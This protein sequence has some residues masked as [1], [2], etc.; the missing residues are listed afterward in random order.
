MQLAATLS[1]SAP[2]AVTAGGEGGVV[3]TP[4][5]EGVGEGAFERVSQLGSHAGAGR[6]GGVVQGAPGQ[7]VVQLVAPVLPASIVWSCLW[8]VQPQ[9]KQSCEVP[10]PQRC[11]E[12]GSSKCA[13]QPAPWHVLICCSS[14]HTGQSGCAAT[15]APGQRKAGAPQALRVGRDPLAV[16]DL[17]V[18][19]GR[20]LQRVASQTRLGYRG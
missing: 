17:L 7:V 18:H 11:T 6:R 16:V 13:Q 9:G 14:L 4:R 19:G 12:I 8:T 15:N 20:Q 3:H 2:E 5:A 1:C 10:V